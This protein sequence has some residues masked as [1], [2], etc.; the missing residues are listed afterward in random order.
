MSY[1]LVSIDGQLHYQFSTEEYVAG[2]VDTFINNFV[3]GAKQQGLEFEVLLHK[4]E[5]EMPSD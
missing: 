1:Y 2:H 3:E 5:G 4:V